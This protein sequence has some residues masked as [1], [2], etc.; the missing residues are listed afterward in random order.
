[1]RSL[2]SLSM[3]AVVALMGGV[4]VSAQD[5]SPAFRPDAMDDRPAGEPNQVMV[6][7]TRIFR[8]GVTV[9]VPRRSSR[10]CPAL[11]NGS[12]QRS[13]RRIVPGFFAI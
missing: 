8:N 10:S 7:A 13:P 12:P 4:A 11:Q 1:M 3:I 6:L 2:A 5:Y 9:S